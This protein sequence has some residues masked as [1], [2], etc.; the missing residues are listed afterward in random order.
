MF[1]Q[2]PAAAAALLAPYFAS[3]PE[4]IVAVLHLDGG[5]RLLATTY[6]ARGGADEVE[7]PVRDILAAALR[8]GAASIVVAH[9][10]PSGDPTPSEADLSATRRL[11]EAAAAAGIRLT[12][13]LVFGEQDCRSF[14]ELG[15]L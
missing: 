10:H 9:N 4:E 11:A 1:V 7:L 5:G 14:R 12:D 3:S 2:T 13:H 15:L 6:S 8:M